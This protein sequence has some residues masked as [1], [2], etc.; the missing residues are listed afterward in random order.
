[1]RRAGDE[2]LL[3]TASTEW[4]FVDLATRLPTRIHPDVIAAFEVVAASE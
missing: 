4:A 3:A 1:M 2:K